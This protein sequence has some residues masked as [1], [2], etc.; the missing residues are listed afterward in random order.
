MFS[1]LK[2]GQQAPNFKLKGAYSNEITKYDLANYKSKWVVLF[3]YPADFTFI[4]PTEVIG[5]N[6]FLDEFNSKNVQVLG[7]SV[8]S[9]YVHLAWSKDLGVVNFPLLS[10]VH[11]TASMDYNVYDEDEAQSL[12]GTFI[13]DPDGNLKW[14]QISDNNIGRSVKEV[15]RVVD[16]LQTGE[17][18]PV[19]WKKGDATLE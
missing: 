9:P 13:I 19:D 15:L 4:C 8:D 12:R 17:K 2:I 5:F 10:D 1:T 16:A 7:C 18:C 14:Y 11:H 6:S 3:F